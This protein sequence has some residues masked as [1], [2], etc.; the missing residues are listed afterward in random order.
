MEQFFWFSLCVALNALLTILLALNVSYRR[1]SLKI[2]NGDGGILDMK[3]AIR[4]H[5]N[6]VEHVT[7]FS[8]IILALCAQEN[9]PAIIGATVILFS[10]ARLLHAISMLNSM[11]NGRRLAA[12]LTYMA[13]LTG[14]LF[15]IYLLIAK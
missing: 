2:A 4:A 5:G 8:L 14:I 1:M 3:K 10:T 9:E 13:E 12:G 7:I 6:S 15:L 11:F